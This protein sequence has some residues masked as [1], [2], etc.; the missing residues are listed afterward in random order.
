MLAITRGY[1]FWNT[2]HESITHPDLQ[3]ALHRRLKIPEC[4]VE[5]LDK[6]LGLHD[7]ESYVWCQKVEIILENS[8]GTIW[9]L[10][11]VASSPFPRLSCVPTTGHSTMLAKLN[12]PGTGDLLVWVTRGCRVQVTQWI[13]IIKILG[14]CRISGTPK[15]YICTMCKTHRFSPN[16][17]WSTF[18]VASPH[19]P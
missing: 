4:C 8:H 16:G 15:W 2:H 9:N 5:T 12:E 1:Y 18:I 3:S 13:L 7:Q 19:H 10:N 6:M 14:I 11:T 17:K